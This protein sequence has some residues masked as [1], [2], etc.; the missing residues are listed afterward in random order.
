[1]KLTD[2]CEV[3]TATQFDSTYHQQVQKKQKYRKIGV[4][5]QI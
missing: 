4:F 2:I 3:N 5:C 1:M